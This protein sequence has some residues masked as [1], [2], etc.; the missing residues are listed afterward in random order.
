MIC[1]MALPLMFPP[2]PMIRP[3]I[4]PPPFSASLPVMLVLN[5]IALCLQLLTQICRAF[6]SGELVI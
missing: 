6:L 3:N 1:F 2:L 4:N 5:L